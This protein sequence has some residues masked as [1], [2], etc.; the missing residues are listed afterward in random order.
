HL[1]GVDPHQGRSLGLTDADDPTQ[2]GLLMVG[3][4]RGIEPVFHLD[5]A[6]LLNPTPGKGA[7][8]MAFNMYHS[9]ARTAAAALNIG[10]A[11]AIGFPDEIDDELSE[12]FFASF[13]REW[14]RHGWSLLEGFRAGMQAVGSDVL[15]GTGIV[16]WSARSLVRPEASAISQPPTGKRRQGRRP[17]GKDQETV[18]SPEAPAVRNPA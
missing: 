10:A 8:L 14:R 15:A 18:P 5:L 13:Y 4:G 3:V 7:Q 16:M 11:A 9:A 12:R 2:D 17:R 6:T 1:S